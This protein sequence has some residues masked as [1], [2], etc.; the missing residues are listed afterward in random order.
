[1]S[2]IK[3][4][5]FKALAIGI[6]VDMAGSFMI[7]IIV[8]FFEISRHK[9]QPAP[10]QLIHFMSSPT[11]IIIVSVLGFIVTVSAGFIAAKIAGIKPILHGSIVGFVPCVF[12]VAFWSKTNSLNI[13]AL[14]INIPAGALGGYIQHHLN[15][16]KTNKR[17]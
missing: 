7:G 13:I 2:S 5:R 11:S 14:I 6:I 4:I 9:L 10:E 8:G 16:N 12:T 15:I 1:M 3:Q 17:P